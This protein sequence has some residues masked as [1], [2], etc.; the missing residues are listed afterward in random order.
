MRENVAKINDKYR[1]AA[2]DILTEVLGPA[3]IDPYTPNWG[4]DDREEVQHVEAGAFVHAWIWIPKERL[5]ESERPE[6]E[7]Q[8]AE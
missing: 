1:T 3:N 4:L 2:R 8:N 7:A 5:N 6:G